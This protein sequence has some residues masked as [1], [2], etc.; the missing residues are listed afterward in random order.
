MKVG[1]CCRCEKFCLV[2]ASVLF[3]LGRD[4]VNTEREIQT[5]SGLGFR[6]LDLQE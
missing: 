4:A 1:L 2:M 5:L 3:P 6:A